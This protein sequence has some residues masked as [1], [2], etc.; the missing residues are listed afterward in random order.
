MNLAILYYDYFHYCEN[1]DDGTLFSSQLF[2]IRRNST[3]MSLGNASHE[4]L[5]FPNQFQLHLLI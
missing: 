2:M 4:A 3:L 5:L 1:P